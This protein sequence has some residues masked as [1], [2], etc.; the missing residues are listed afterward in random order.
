MRRAPL[1]CERNIADRLKFAKLM[2]SKGLFR[3]RKGKQILDTVMFTDKSTI[4]F[5]I[6]SNPQ[7]VGF[8]T[9]SKNQVPLIPMVHSQGEKITVA[10]GLTSQGL[11]DL[12]II[13]EDQN[14]TA[15]VY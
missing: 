6:L 7:N 2:E 10:A 13:H 4:H 11:N 14:I 5:I 9:T 8:R 1:L 15:K 3:A 12:L